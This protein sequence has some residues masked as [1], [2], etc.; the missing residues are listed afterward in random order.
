M[1]AYKQIDQRL[2]WLCQVIAKANRTFASKKEDDSHTNLYFD[3]IGDRIVGR[4]LKT[5]S[6]AC[7]LSLNLNNLH[8]EWLNTSLQKVQSIAS[9][10]KRMI[11]IESELSAGLAELGLSKEGFTASLHFEITNYTFAGD[12]VKPLDLSAL[13]EWKYWRKFAADSCMTLLGYMQ[14]ESEIRIW[15]HHFDTGIFATYESELGIGYGLAMQDKMADAPYFYLT[16]YLG[17]KAIHYKE[18]PDLELGFWKTDGPWKGAILPLSQ[19][20]Q[21]EK[22]DRCSALHKFLKPTID[23]F[24]LN[25]Q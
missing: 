9:V 12:E 25:A 18:L 23:W 16:G 3:V 2:H 20:K 13:E 4:W 11:E 6:G 5:A 15:P 24:A 17:K 8:F 21:L 10:G 14:A 7:L 1:Q 19:L 22:V